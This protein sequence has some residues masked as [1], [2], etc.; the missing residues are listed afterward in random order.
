[1]LTKPCPLQDLLQ[2]I[3]AVLRRSS[4]ADFSSLG[5]G[6]NLDQRLHGFDTRAIRPAN[7]RPVR[8]SE[9]QSDDHADV[10]PVQAAYSL[11]KLKRDLGDV[12]VAAIWYSTR[13]A[14]HLATGLLRDLRF[15]GEHVSAVVKLVAALG[16]LAGLLLE[17]AGMLPDL[18]TLNAHPG[19]VGEVLSK[20]IC[21]IDPACRTCVTARKHDTR[22]EELGESH[23]RRAARTDTDRVIVAVDDEHRALVRRQHAGIP[24]SA[25]SSPPGGGLFARGS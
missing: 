14:L 20:G 22:A 13:A 25:R 7:Q 24:C 3:R 4:A 23:G 19:A 15:A 8:S 17:F 18:A 16:G 12:S 1:M 5:R 9:Q 11:P 21:Q 2:E 10:G 6:T